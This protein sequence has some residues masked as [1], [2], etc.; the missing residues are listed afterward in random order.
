MFCS[1]EEKRIAHAV[2][3]CTW[4]GEKIE[5]RFPYV[6]WVSIDD[7]VFTNKMHTECLKACRAETAFYG[8]DDYEPFDNKRPPL[9]TVEK[10]IRDQP[11]LARVWMEPV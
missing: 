9:T 11:M 10:A 4:C 2:H 3:R 8:D 7:S 6:R 5:R 1:P